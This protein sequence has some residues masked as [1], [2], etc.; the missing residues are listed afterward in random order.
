ML[1][2]ILISDIKISWLFIDLIVVQC[3][4]CG[5]NRPTFESFFLYSYARETVTFNDHYESQLGESEPKSARS[6]VYKLN[7]QVE[8]E[9]SASRWN[10]ST[11]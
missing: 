2:I 5:Q 11:N 10:Q 6:R 9:S 7:W 4:N 3:R 1:S 8:K